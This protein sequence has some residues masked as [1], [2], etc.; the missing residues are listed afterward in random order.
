MK[1]VLI[2]I[3]LLAGA[4]LLAAPF[5]RMKPNYVE[6]GSPKTL[7][8][9]WL[10]LMSDAS[11]PKWMVMGVVVGVAFSMVMSPAIVYAEYVYAARPLSG[12]VR[13]LF[14]AQAVG[15]FIS[16]AVTLLLMTLSN[17]LIGFGS[18]KL[19]EPT[20]VFGVI[21]AMQIIGAVG[22]VALVFA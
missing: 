10:K 19:T 22:S 14:L 20:V 5:E 17:M 9:T 21:L 12:S 13:A 18:A 6:N 2:T 3:L 11:R 4:A 16:A 1:P 8:G 7:F 15:C